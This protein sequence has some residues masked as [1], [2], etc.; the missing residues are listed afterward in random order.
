MRSRDYTHPATARTNGCDIQRVQKELCSAAVAQCA[1][2]GSSFYVSPPSSWV[3]D[4]TCSTTEW[5]D[6]SACSVLCGAGFRAR[7]RRFFNRLGRKKCPHID[8]VTKQRCRGEQVNCDQVEEEMISAECPV[9]DW[10]N[11]SPCSQ[12]CGSG[13]HVRTRLYRVSKEEQLAAGCS[14]QLVEKGGC[15]GQSRRCGSGP[16]SDQRQVCQ[17]EKQVGPCRGTFK[18]WYYD[19]NSKQCREFFFGGCRGNSNNFIKYEDCDKRC[20]QRDVGN[21]NQAKEIFQNDQFRN[22]LDVLVKRRRK[23]SANSMNDAFI[24]IEE[25][26]AVVQKLEM[27]KQ[28]ALDAGEDF[29]DE[30]LEAAM[31]KLMMMERMKDK[32]VMMSKQ[33]MMAKQRMETEQ[34]QQRMMRN[35]MRN[36]D[37]PVISRNITLTEVRS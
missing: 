26:K 16:G 23:A 8:T 12:S 25:Q 27:E 7:T 1:T 4:D 29:D 34:R 36:Q 14:V 10:S 5:T 33:R 18:R 6:W 21:R 31:K 37:E 17:Q 30:G 2:G 11:W 3:P 15:T 35:K 22:A 9:T 24:E 20:Q 19:T 28:I 32:Q 13:L